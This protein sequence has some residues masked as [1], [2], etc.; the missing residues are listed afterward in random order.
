MRTSDSTSSCIASVFL[1][2]KASVTC[3]IVGYLCPATPNSRRALQ[4]KATTSENL[5]GGSLTLGRLPQQ[6]RVLLQLQGSASVAAVEL[7]RSS[8]Q[9]QRSRL[10]L[11]LVLHSRAR[12]EATSC[13]RTR[14]LRIRANRVSRGDKSLAF[15]RQSRQQIGQQFMRYSHCKGVWWDK[16]TF[17]TGIRERLQL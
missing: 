1:R 17:A 6:R 5:A 11:M 10:A 9:V 14:K 4:S 13:G 8:G 2:R 16:D 7:T 12:F 15:A 3:L